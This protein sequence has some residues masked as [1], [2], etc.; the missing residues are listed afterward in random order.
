MPTSTLFVG[1]DTSLKTNQACAINFILDTFFNKSFDN[2]PSGTEQ[3]TLRILDIFNKHK[4]LNKLVI[5]MEAT[6]VYH[7]H[8]SSILANEFRF[9]P[10]DCKVYVQNAKSIEK[11]KETFMDRSKTD[12]EDAFLCADYARVGKCKDSHPVIGYQKIALQRL[13]RQRR[14]VAE[15]LGKEK[16]YVSSN[17]Y[18]KFSAMKVNSELNPFSNIYS[19]TSSFM[20]TDF[21]TNEEI[22]N[23]DIS[24]L[25][26]KLCEL[27][28]NRFDDSEL[29]AKNLKKMARDSYR[30]DKVSADSISSALA[31]SF[32]LIQVYEKELKE[33][34][35]EILRLI[36]GL[37]NNYLTILTSIKGVGLVYSAGIIAEIDNIGFFKDDNHLASYCGLRWKRKDSG[38]KK[39]EHRKQTNACNTY[40]R[41]YIV[42]ATG[43]IIRYNDEYAAYYYKKRK[44]VKINA[45]KRALVLTARKFVRLLFGLLRNNKLYDNQ[46]NLTVNS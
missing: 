34:D 31:S 3:L 45:H 26:S 42:E 18:L 23:A 28:K 27:S 16:Q 30:L 41:Y 11:Y 17:L 1:I 8:V 33:L 4:E 5:C 14:H 19:K 25:V 22:I 24:D 46:H 44:E 20:L 32:R 43:S 15:Q 2:S 10:Y 29:V 7:I 12:P 9:Q 37:N 36:E 6:N 38:S 21:L 39:S 40:L 35:K 13:T